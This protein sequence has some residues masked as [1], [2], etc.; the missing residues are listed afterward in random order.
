[1]TDML[2]VAVLACSAWAWIWIKVLTVLAEQ[3]ETQLEHQRRLHQLLVIAVR[4]ERADD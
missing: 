2:W 3:G 4:S 1:M